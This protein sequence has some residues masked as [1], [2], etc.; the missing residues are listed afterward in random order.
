MGSRVYMMT[1][2]WSSRDTLSSH[3]K[4]NSR[5]TV[6]LSHPLTRWGPYSPRP[7]PPPCTR[8]VS[9]WP[10]AGDQWGRVGCDREKLPSRQRH[11]QIKDVWSL[12]KRGQQCHVWEA[13]QGFDHCWEEKHCWSNVHCKRYGIVNEWFSVYLLDSMWVDKR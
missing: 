12:A 13:S 7:E 9:T 4:R 6:T 2:W 10:P 5:I 1:M 8:L 11:V 3:G